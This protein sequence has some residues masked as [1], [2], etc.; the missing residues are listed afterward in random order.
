MAKR[1]HWAP[2]VVLYREALESAPRQWQWRFEL[3]D[4]LVAGQR[5]DAALAVLEGPTANRPMEAACL[6]AT[7]LARSGQ[8]ERARAQMEK[9]WPRGTSVRRLG[10]RT[11]APQAIERL[12]AALWHT[13]RHE[14]LLGVTDGAPEN[15]FGDP[16]PTWTFA[17]GWGCLLR[18][19]VA[20]A[21]SVLG[22]MKS[23]GVAQ[24]GDIP[25]RFAHRGLH[26]LAELAFH[27]VRE[28][29]AV[30][31]RPEGAGEVPAS[32]AAVFQ[33]SA[34]LEGWAAV[35]AFGGGR[36][37]TP[38]LSEDA[39]FTLALRAAPSWRRLLDR[40]GPDNSPVRCL[41]TRDEALDVLGH[42]GAAGAD[43]AT[44]RAEA[45]C[46]AL[47]ARRPDLPRS[48]RALDADLAMEETLARM[49]R[50][51]RSAAAQRML[52]AYAAEVQARTAAVAGSAVG[53]GARQASGGRTTST[54]TPSHVDL[55]VKLLGHPSWRLL[56]LPLKATLE[57]LH[58]LIQ[59]AFE[60]DDDHPYRFAFG[61]SP[62]RFERTF[63]G[64]GTEDQAAPDVRLADLP[65]VP[66]RRFWYIFDFGDWHQFSVS[67]VAMGTHGGSADREARLLKI[68]GEA[69]QQYAEDEDGG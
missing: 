9:A 20:E 37:R 60:W 19:Q 6:R 22:P 34:A 49:Q 1:G 21:R 45:V 23:Y 40:L 14:E 39:L 24:T 29:L 38:R 3:C 10:K 7:V 5:W 51:A 16:R 63:G 65:L 26:W 61:R 46:A 32:V 58:Y 8:A 2:A 15:P 47:H 12:A 54:A 13:G 50:G 17:R 33:Q 68:Y 67:V 28:A 18:R 41:A 57:N 62:R 52:T 27:G 59:A 48:E 31:P 69:P 43:A 4:L 56:R 53:H 35:V 25:A 11:E 30:V 44:R 64:P 36:D 55:R 66:G 42:G